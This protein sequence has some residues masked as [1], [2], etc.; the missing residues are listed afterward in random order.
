MVYNCTP[1]VFRACFWA[2]E[3]KLA[4]V[5]ALAVARNMARRDKLGI[6]RLSRLRG[7]P[8]G[9]VDGGGLRYIHV[10]GQG[11]RFIEDLLVYLADVGRR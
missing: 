5:I 2:A 9:Q 4:V 10:Y 6:T 7:T 1:I 8:N 3:A 11:S